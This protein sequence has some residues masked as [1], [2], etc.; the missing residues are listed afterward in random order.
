MG[1][2]QRKREKN[3][4]LFAVYDCSGSCHVDRPRGRKKQI[5]V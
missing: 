2:T 4:E 3:K 1:K 5:G